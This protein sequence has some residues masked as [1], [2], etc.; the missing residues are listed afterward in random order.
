MEL[1]AGKKRLT[2]SAEYLLKV[3]LI[4][5]NVALRFVN[6]I[7]A[8]LSWLDWENGRVFY[9]HPKVTQIEKGF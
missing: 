9:F 6:D 3:G 5:H 2:I 8:M 4:R 1:N 7:K